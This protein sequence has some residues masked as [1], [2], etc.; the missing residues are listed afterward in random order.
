[1]IDYSALQKSM[2]A[3]VK[4]DEI[5]RDELQR[6]RAENAQLRERAEKEFPIIASPN[7][8]AHPLRIPWSIA[9]LAYSRYS[10]RYETYQS[11]QRLAERGGFHANEMD[12]FVPDWRDQCNEITLWKQL[13]ETT[14]HE[15]ETARTRIKELEEMMLDHAKASA[16][17]TTQC[18]EYQQ[19]IEVARAELA[20][21]REQLEK[22]GAELW[23]G[24]SENNDHYLFTHQPTWDSDYREWEDI[25]DE[26]PNIYIGAID[27]GLKPGESCKLRLVLDTPEREE[28]KETTGPSA[29]E[30]HRTNWRPWLTKKEAE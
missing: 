18:L 16:D 12:C 5:E 23:I 13:A 17:A 10:A 20:A 3:K 7:V 24:A 26:N 2:A 19:Q 30:W 11:L 29:T 8:K 21:L 27:L 9:E 25:F 6:L 1:M 28:K 14:K 22:A 15:L 4:A